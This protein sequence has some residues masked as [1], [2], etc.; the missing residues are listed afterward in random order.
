MI[1]H[2]MTRVGKTCVITPG[3]DVEVW[4][5]GNTVPGAWLR[6]VVASIEDDLYCVGNVA[7]SGRLWVKRDRVRLVKRVRD[8]RKRP[9][10]KLALPCRF[11]KAVTK[12]VKA[13]LRCF[14]RRKRCCY[15][16]HSLRTRH[17]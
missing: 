5:S 8:I 11:L 16:G 1:V 3:D 9:E 2:V 6:A 12:V 14:V 15:L 7:S 17:H 4:C 10:S 13:I